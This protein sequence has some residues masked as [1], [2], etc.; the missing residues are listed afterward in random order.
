[1][2]STVAAL[3][4]VDAVDGG[5]DQHP[6]QGFALAGQQQ[7]DVGRRAVQQGLGHALQHHAAVGPGRQRQARRQR[8]GRHHRHRPGQLAR[9]KPRRPGRLLRRVAAA[10]QGLDDQHR[11]QHRQRREAPSQ[12]LVDDRQFGRSQ[13]EPAVRLVGG[14]GQPAKLGR[15][16]PQG[17]VAHALGVGEGGHL[18]VRRLL[19]QHRPHA[20]AQRLQ[21]HAVARMSVAH[22]RPLRTARRW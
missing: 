16:R 13:T 6:A 20:V 1:V 15:L 19:G 3:S 14:Q 9:R 8:S 10:R 4:T 17:L 11:A 18:L 21:V 5:L 12:F 2:R 7:Q 22:R